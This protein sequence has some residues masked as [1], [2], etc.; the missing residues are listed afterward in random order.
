MNDFILSAKQAEM[1]KFANAR[2]N[3]FDGAVRT[4]KTQ[5]GFYLLPKRIKQFKDTK[6]YFTL[7][8]KTEKTIVRNVIMPLQELYGKEFISDINYKKGECYMFGERFLVLPANDIQSASK[9]QGMT[10]K[11]GFN[12]EAALYPETFFKQFQARLSAPGAMCDNFLNPESPY[13]YFKRDI[14]DNPNIDKF[15]INFVLDDGAEFL[16]P[17][18]MENLKKEYSGVYK[19]RYIDGQWAIA[20]GSIYD[21]WLDSE[22]IIEELDFIPEYYFTAID[23][24]TASVCTFILFAVKGDEVRAIKQYYYDAVKTGR[25]KTDSQYVTDYSDF[26]SGYEVRYGYIDPSASSLK[27]ELRT[28]GFGYFR[29]ASNEV[30]DGIKTVQKFISKRKYKVLSCCKELIREKYSY[31]WDKKAQILGED[32]PIKQDD[33]SSDAERYGLHSHLRR[34]A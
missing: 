14:I 1:L 30:L 25:Q 13:H 7:S 4:G 3:I 6:G 15:R 26:V 2:I 31:A 22:N 33:H 11:Y 12:D 28:S 21:M 20:E 5:G 19:K 16:D 34:I 8:G 29:S 18:Y 10:I 32:A 24:A 17:T 9:I 27:L 23:Y